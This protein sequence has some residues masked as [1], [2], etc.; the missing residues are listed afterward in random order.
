M[1]FLVQIETDVTKTSIQHASESVPH[2]GQR[3]LSGQTQPHDPVQTH[4]VGLMRKHQ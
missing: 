3:S 2:Q 4:F 1:H